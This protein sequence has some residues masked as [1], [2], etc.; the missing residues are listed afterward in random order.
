MGRD[1]VAIWLASG[2]RTSIRAEYISSTTRGILI[3][4]ADEAN[5]PYDDTQPQPS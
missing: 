1:L 5:D 2:Y 4:A 3:P